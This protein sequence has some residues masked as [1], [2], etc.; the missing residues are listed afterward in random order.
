MDFVA[1][2]QAT[3]H[4]AKTRTETA[5][6]VRLAV[7][8]GFGTWRQNEAVGEEDVVAVRTN[9]LALI[10]VHRALPH[11][12]HGANPRLWARHSGIKNFPRVS[13][14]EGG[15]CPALAAGSRRADES[16]H[17]L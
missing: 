16:R 9:L 1:Q 15:R 17:L 10:D 11:T 13:L 12:R 2:T 7:E 6:V 14:K 4:I 3:F 5:L 8:V